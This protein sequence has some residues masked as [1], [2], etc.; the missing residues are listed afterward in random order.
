MKGGMGSS[1]SLPHP[2]TTLLVVYA[3]RAKREQLKQFKK[4]K[5]KTQQTQP[6]TL[7][8]GAPM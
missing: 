2:H 5:K 6:Y 7:K 4:K 8:V 1:P 3:G